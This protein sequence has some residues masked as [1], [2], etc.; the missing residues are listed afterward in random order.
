MGNTIGV[1][2]RENKVLGMARHEQDFM[3]LVTWFYNLPLTFIQI[4][5]SFLP[6]SE[7]AVYL[8]D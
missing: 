7:V 2:R 3:Q 8:I 5:D 6:T 4:P 1:I